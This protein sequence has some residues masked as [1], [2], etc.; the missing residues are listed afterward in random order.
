MKNAYDRSFRNRI[1][2]RQLS[3]RRRRYFVMNNR[4]QGGHESP[5]PSSRNDV[6]PRNHVF[7]L[8]RITLGIIYRKLLGRFQPLN[9]RC[10]YRVPKHK[11]R[12]CSTSTIIESRCELYICINPIS[13]TAIGDILEQ[14]K[15][16]A[17]LLDARGFSA[18]LIV[19]GAKGSVSS[20][21]GDYL[22]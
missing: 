15:F 22:I 14:V 18:R 5:H 3:G 17:A 16:P 1:G 2:A 7:Q 10:E 11:A 6:C 8:P 12:P 13:P 19:A 9:L 21:L 4:M 20:L